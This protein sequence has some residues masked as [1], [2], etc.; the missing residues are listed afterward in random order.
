[1]IV[2][3]GLIASAFNST[4]KN[5]LD[6]IFFASGVSNSRESR[7]EEFLREKKMLLNFLEKGK[8]MVY[9]ST[10]SINDPELFDTPYV[11][12]KKEMELLVCTAGNYAIFRLPQV[13]GKSAN[14]HTLTNYIYNKIMSGIHFEIWRNAKRNFIDVEH[15]HLIVLYFLRSCLV[16]KVTI[17]VACPFSTSINHL[18]GIFESELGRSANSTLVEGGG[19]YLIESSLAA[20]AAEKVGIDF[21]D[22]YIKKLVK[23]YYELELTK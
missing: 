19:E 5:D 9:F 12:H 7:S 16:N 18:V 10:C 4:I 22:T 1:M 2:G 15:V 6:M 3:N 11:R 21:H 8:F 23:K 13:V 14:P 20:M 17:N